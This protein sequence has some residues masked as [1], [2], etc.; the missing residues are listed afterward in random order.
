MDELSPLEFGDKTSQSD[1][2]QSGS[3]GFPNDANQG[4]PSVVL[5]ANR[6]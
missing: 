3:L 5:N 6:P 2:S 4:T 1:D